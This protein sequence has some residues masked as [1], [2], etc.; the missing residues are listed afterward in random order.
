MIPIREFLQDIDLK[1]NKVGTNDH[2]SVPPEDKIRFINDAIINLIK[3]KL[4]E[5]NIFRSGIDSNTKRYDDLQTLVV[6][7]KLLLKQ[8]TNTI[9][10][11][12]LVEPYM[13]YIGGFI[14]ADKDSCS[15]RVIVV[16]LTKHADVNMVIINNNTKPSFEYQETIGTISENIINIYTDGS[17]KPNEIHIEY[18]KYPKKVDVAGYEHLYGETSTN[19]D[20]DLPYYL[21]EEIVDIAVRNIAMSIDN[22]NI[23]Q[24]T[25]QKLQ[26][27][28]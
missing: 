3:Q 24:N 1:L 2:Q 10:S 7:Q 12:N 19:V 8:S 27:E 4:S 18:I 25:T 17:F 22:Q 9:Y 6:G 14:I 5:N 20:S 28:E 15:N 11:A 16:R 21:K 26:N 13:F 23:V